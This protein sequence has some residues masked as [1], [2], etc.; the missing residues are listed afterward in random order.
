M[1][2]VVDSAEKQAARE[3]QEEFYAQASRMRFKRVGA[4]IKLAREPKNDVINTEETSSHQSESY[5]PMEEVEISNDMA[6][7]SDVKP[8]ATNS[9]RHDDGED[10]TSD[11]AEAFKPVEEV[12]IVHDV[13]TIQ[14]RNIDLDPREIP[15]LPRLC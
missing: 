3:R 11:N 14:E 15:E 4:T 9:G 12:E 7:I 10:A 1:L 13:E 6:V 2:F 8:T 5:K